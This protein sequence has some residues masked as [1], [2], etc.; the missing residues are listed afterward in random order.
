MVQE[1]VGWPGI[2]WLPISRAEEHLL[3]SGHLRT[4]IIICT[5]A[6]KHIKRL[7]GNYAGSA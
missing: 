1:E 4:I 7:S 6:G 3:V 5:M 2:I